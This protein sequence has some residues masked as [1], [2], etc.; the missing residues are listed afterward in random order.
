[1]AR[2]TDYALLDN[3]LLALLQMPHAERT[4]DQ[5]RA[6]LSLAT[7]AAALDL[8][9]PS[10]LQREQMK[11]ASACALLAASLGEGFIYRVNLRLGPGTEGI[12]LFASVENSTANLRFTGFGHTAAGALAML[13]QDVDQHGR[14]VGSPR[15]RRPREANRNPLRLLPREARRA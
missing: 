15:E 2:I 9:E 6:H 5:I 1:M 11:L 3:A 4:R 7:S 8:S 12:E 10:P 14:G 13:R